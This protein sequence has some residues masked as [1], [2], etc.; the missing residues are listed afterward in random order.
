MARPSLADEIVR[1]INGTWAEDPSLSAAGV[2][3]ILV[4][5]H[6][7]GYVSLSKV[8]QIVGEAKQGGGGKFR[9]TV[10]QPWVS[11]ECTAED[12]AYLFRLNRLCFELN[13]RFLY[14]HEAHWARLLRASLEDLEL[15]IQFFLIFLYAYREQLGRNLGYDHT[16]TEY[17]DAFITFQP[18]TED[19]MT[20]YVKAVENDQVP[21][22][23]FEPI[24][25]RKL[26]VFDTIENEVSDTPTV[27]GEDLWESL[28][29]FRPYTDKIIDIQ[30]FFKEVNPILGR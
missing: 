11:P 18:W 10:W 8:Q 21:P 17:Y 30:E 13:S 19:G 2:H 15:P 3:R 23:Y 7:E 6:G 29:S 1:E 12:I 25:K 14:Q 5:T 26:K 9:P 4:L 27:K 24:L 16:Y 28:W 20:E 22:I